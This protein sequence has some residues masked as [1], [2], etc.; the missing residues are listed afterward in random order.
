[1]LDHRH[2]LTDKV[3]DPGAGGQ[4]KVSQNPEGSK[5]PDIEPE[6]QEQVRD[7][8]ESKDHSFAAVLVPTKWRMCLYFQRQHFVCPW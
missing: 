3:R 4:N 7:Y 5:D 8:F 6:M 1:M 2:R